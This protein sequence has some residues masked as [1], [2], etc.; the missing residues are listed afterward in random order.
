MEIMK[1]EQPEM[2]LFVVCFTTARSE[3]RTSVLYKIVC[4]AA[5]TGRVWDM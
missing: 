3:S 4:I 2:W 1:T 5:F